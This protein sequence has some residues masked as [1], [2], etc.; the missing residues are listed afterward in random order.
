M[1][2]YYLH[3]VKYLF[4]TVEI[5][6]YGTGSFEVFEKEENVYLFIPVSFKGYGS[7]PSKLEIKIIKG[8]YFASPANHSFESNLTEA[9]QQ[10]LNSL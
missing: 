1:H 6:H 10:Y 2:F 9:L 8:K 5:N 7:K 4:K 3:F